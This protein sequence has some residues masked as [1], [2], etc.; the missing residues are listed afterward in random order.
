MICKQE[1][2][3]SVILTNQE[4]NAKLRHKLLVTEFRMIAPLASPRLSHLWC[5]LTAGTVSSR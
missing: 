3:V 1:V 5:E 4:N 2:H